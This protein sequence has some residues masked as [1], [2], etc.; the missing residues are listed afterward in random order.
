[1]GRK[2]PNIKNF[3]SSGHLFQEFGSKL[4]KDVCFINDIS[5]G[6]TFEVTSEQ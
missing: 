5:L 1:V 2:K 4:H 3:S 6:V